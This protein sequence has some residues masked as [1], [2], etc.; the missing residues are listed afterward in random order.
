M[1]G[2]FDDE[3]DEVMNSIDQAEVMS[4]FFPTLRTAV[5]VDTRCNDDEGPLVRIMPMAASPEERLRSLRKLRPSFP[6]LQA[7]TLVP[8]TRYVDSLVSLGVWERLVQRV[9]ASGY[10]EAVAALD[11]ILE[12]LRRLEKAEMVS[13]VRGD[14]YHTL[15]SARG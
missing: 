3:L 1:N 14:N 7:L 10:P 5:I 13:V 11:P 9:G 15:W 4:L 2:D 8:W 6:R 12:E